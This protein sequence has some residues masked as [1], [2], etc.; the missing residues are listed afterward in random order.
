MEQPDAHFRISLESGTFEV[1]GSE[2]FVQQQIDKFADSIE[3]LPAEEIAQSPNGGTEPISQ[4][5]NRYPNVI[6]F[7]GNEVRVIAKI[8]GTKD[9]TVNA[10]LIC[11]AGK[12]LIGENRATFKEIRVICKE[13]AFLDS[14][15]FSQYLRSEKLFFN[16]QGKNGGALQAELTF[17]GRKAARELVERLNS[18]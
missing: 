2:T 3:G 17:P 1:S 10:A 16:I 14:S 18:A 11:L 4:E 6:V 9:K 12:E 5:P 8:P 7:N 15:N 13:H